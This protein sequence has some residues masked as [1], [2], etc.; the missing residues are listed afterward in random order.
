MVPRQ[1]YSASVLNVYSRGVWHQFL[2][3]LPEIAVFFLILSCLFQSFC[4][5]SVIRRLCWCCAECSSLCWHPLFIGIGSTE[6][7][8]TAFCAT[9]IVDG[10]FCSSVTLMF[11]KRS[12]IHLIYPQPWRKKGLFKSVF[13]ISLATFK[14]F[15]L[16]MAGISLTR[17]FLHDLFG[18]LQGLYCSIEL[19]WS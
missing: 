19:F 12:L 1:R 18:P 8:C 14:R 13:T 6:S 5:F 15:S 4:Y 10:A 17:T 16:D 2:E 11:S 7:T 9:R 3:L